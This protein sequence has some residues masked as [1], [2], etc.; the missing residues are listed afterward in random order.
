MLEMTT[1]HFTDEYLLPEMMERVT[2][3]E[4]RLLKSAKKSRQT[5]VYLQIHRRCV[6]LVV[7]HN[8][9]PDTR[10]TSMES[11][12]DDINEALGELEKKLEAM[13]V[14]GRETGELL[15]IVENRQFLRYAGNTFVFRFQF[16]SY[17]NEYN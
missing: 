17:K 14:G 9:P 10:K 1:K 16:E 5:E 7:C 12:F 2:R 15:R 8:L 6:R 3:L 11:S 4:N 13:D